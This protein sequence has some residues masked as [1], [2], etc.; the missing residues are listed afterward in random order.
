MSW[1]NSILDISKLSGTVDLECK[2]AVGKNGKGV[3][4]IWLEEMTHA[5]A[6]VGK[7]TKNAV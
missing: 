6:V 3:V 2:L 5:P 7:N 4:S 1:L